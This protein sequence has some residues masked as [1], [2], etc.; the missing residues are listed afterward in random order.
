MQSVSGI[1]GK[2]EHLRRLQPDPLAGDGS[3]YWE[4]PEY[5]FFGGPLKQVR[6]FLADSHS[7][8]LSACSRLLQF[9][10]T[11]LPQAQRAGSKIG[12]QI[13][14]TL[15]VHCINESQPC[16]RARTP[17]TFPLVLERAMASKSKF[18]PTIFQ[19]LSLAFTVQWDFM[20]LSFKTKKSVKEKPQ[21]TLM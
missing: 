10:S 8:F 20:N 13:L 21:S 11:C 16:N 18:P 1:L 4:L 3:S 9:G 15:N 2:G 19:Q 12:F 6:A 5:D 17:S 14:Y 7:L